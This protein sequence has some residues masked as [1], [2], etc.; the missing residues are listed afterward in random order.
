M[1][2]AEQEA[3]RSLC[4]R[5]ESRFGAIAVKDGK[6]IAT[7]YNGAVAGIRPCA[8]R[9][10]CVRKKRGVQ[11]G[12]RREIAYCICAEQRMICNAA[13]NGV[14]LDGADV[15][16]TGISCSYCVR[17]MTECGVKRVFQKDAARIYMNSFT[18]E[19]ADEAGLELIIVD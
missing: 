11:S 5:P 17:L 19:I 16:V 7:G 6:I 18:K 2:Y 14:N 4:F 12:T 1:N 15:Y 9:G 8:E 13:R 3:E 10:F